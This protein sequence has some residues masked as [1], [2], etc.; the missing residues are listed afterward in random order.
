[1][2][3]YISRKIDKFPEQKIPNNLCRCYILKEVQPNCPLLTGGLL[4]GTL[5][6]RVRYGN[7]EGAGLDGLRWLS[8][9]RVGFRHSAQWGLK[10]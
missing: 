6:Q 9:E 4:T 7:E 8:I 1:M 5:F 2:I 3:R 10:Q